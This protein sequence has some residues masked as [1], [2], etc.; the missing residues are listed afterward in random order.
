MIDAVGWGN[1]SAPLYLGTPASH[2]PE[3]ESLARKSSDN[4]FS[5][6][7][8]N[9]E[10]FLGSLPT[11]RNSHYSGDGEKE[12]LIYASVSGN[13]P[14]IT[15]LSLPYDDSEDEGIQIMPL[16][17]KT[18]NLTFEASISDSDGADDL[19]LVSASFNQGYITL[20][21]KETLNATSEVFEGT[22]SLEFYDSPGI[23]TLVVSATDS[24]NLSASAN[25]SLEYLPIVAF[26]L[27]TSEVH[28]AGISG[29]L[30]E[31][32]GDT[33]LSTFESPTIRNLGNTELDF[34]IFATDLDSGSGTIPV[35]NLYFSFFDND[36]EAELSGPLGKSAIFNEVNLPASALS[37]RELSLRLL[38]PLGTKAGDYEGRIYLQGMVS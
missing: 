29:Q 6:T 37:L 21:K 23:Y 34:G 38:I 5:D 32:I 36:F 13:N 20:T 25:L 35:E 19:Y 4:K 31:A 15:G 14:Q 12:L 18:R 1:P 8:N 17:G 26:G 30:S 22:I 2:V 11:P 28:L 10:D 9:S 3:G 27:D 24:S 7:K 33:D 16:P